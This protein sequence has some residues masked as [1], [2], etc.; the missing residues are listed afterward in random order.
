MFLIPSLIVCLASC[1]SIANDVNGS[2]A[3]SFSDGSEGTCNI[4]NKRNAMS[5][6]IPS[7][8]MVRRSDY[9]LKYECITKKGKKVSVV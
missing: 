4:S 5:V 3:L 7:T 9:V 1:T 6:N 8:S 2:R